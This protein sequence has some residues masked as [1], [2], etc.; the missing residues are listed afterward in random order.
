LFGEFQPPEVRGRG[1]KFDSHSLSL[2]AQFSQIHDP[3]FHLFLRLRIRDHQYRVIVHFVLQHQQSAVRA[4]HQR[5][6]HF[7]EFFAVMCASLCLYFYLA[8]YSRTAPRRCKFSCGVHFPIF[9]PASTPVNCPDGQMYRIRNRAASL[10]LVLSLSPVL[11]F[12]SS[13]AEP[14]FLKFISPRR[15]ILI[16]HLVLI[17]ERNHTLFCPYDSGR[18]HRFTP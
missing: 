8:K 5:L 15:N 14:H 7:A 10:P 3:A 17:S 16:L 1:Q 13:G 2:I 9:D 6:A 12:K 18:I 11:Q 4:H